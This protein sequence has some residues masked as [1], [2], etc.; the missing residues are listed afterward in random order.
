MPKIGGKRK[1]AADKREA[2]KRGETFPEQRL[3]D[4]HSLSNTSDLTYQPL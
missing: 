1:A 4:V 2:S 3:P